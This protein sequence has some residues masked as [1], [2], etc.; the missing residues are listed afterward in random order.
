MT[1]A[2]LVSRPLP[3]TRAGLPVIDVDTHAGVSYLHL[4]KYLSQRWR[5]WLSQVGMR[6]GT[7][8]AGQLPRQRAFAHRLDTVPP[9]GMPPG[10]DEEF[11]REQHLDFYDLTAAMLNPLSVDL[12]GWEPAELGRE[13][14]RAVNEQMRDHWLAVDKRWHGAVSVP[15]EQ[16]E[17]AAAEIARCA[18]EKADGVQ[19][20]HIGLPSRTDRPIGN[21]RYW[22]IFEAAEHFDIPVAFHVGATRSSQVTACGWPSYY[23]ED[24]V[25]FAQQN[26]SLVPS[27]I[28]EGVFERFPKLKVVLIE[29]GW[30]WVPAFAWRLD[31]SYRVMHKEVP[32]LTKLPSEYL[33]EHFWYSTQPM[34]EPEDPR[35]FDDVLAYCDRFGIGDRLM[36]SSDYPHWDFDSPQEAVPASVPHETK[37][38]ILAGIASELYNIPLPSAVGSSPV[39]ESAR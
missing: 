13:Y 19:W 17:H 14:Q 33:Q 34:E 21:P 2:Q 23:F 20:A 11:A 39:A 31:A 4:F 10:S 6:A 26:F 30:S 25:G 24:H 35:W 8:V 5:E 22:P 1:Q 37:A 38:K 28:F 7:S 32:H 9:N 29:L 12:G 3:G 16:P 15:V 36:F 27:M 18:G